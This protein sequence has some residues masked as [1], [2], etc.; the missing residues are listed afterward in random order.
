MV[1]KSNSTSSSQ[2]WT[3]TDVGGGYVRIVN[4]FSGKALEVTGGSTSNGALVRQN[5]Y[6]GATHQKWQLTQ[7]ETA[8]T[9]ATNQKL[10]LSQVE[11]ATAIMN[12][13]N[14]SDN[15]QFEFKL[16]PNPANNFI[17][18]S[19]PIDEKLSISIYD[20]KGSVVLKTSI[21]S[22]LNRIDISSIQSGVYLMRVV[23]TERT[24]ALQFIKKE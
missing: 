9:V 12:S 22:K 10:Q 24:E 14:K 20:I 1:T 18:I 11:S 19:W 3:V 16:Y 5:T 8:K 7:V 21:D 15:T 23:G 17:S 2:K 4:V 6:T 13:F